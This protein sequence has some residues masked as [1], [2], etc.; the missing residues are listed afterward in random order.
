MNVQTKL[1]WTLGI[2]NVNKIIARLESY[3]RKVDHFNAE[4]LFK[5]C[6]EGK[7][8]ETPYMSTVCDYFTNDLFKH[9]IV[10]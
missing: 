2:E 6:Y 7:L 3:G 10:N 9:G 4:T 1:G 8:F 5:N